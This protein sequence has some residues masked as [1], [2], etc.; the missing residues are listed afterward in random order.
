MNH[1]SWR[2]RHRRSASKLLDGIEPAVTSDARLP[3]RDAPLRLLDAALRIDPPYFFGAGD[4]AAPICRSNPDMLARCHISTIL[5]LAI[6]SM[7][8]P[9]YLTCFPVGATPLNSPW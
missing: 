2:C 9:E 6:R 1:K 3:I 7:A 8:I 4:G 5:P